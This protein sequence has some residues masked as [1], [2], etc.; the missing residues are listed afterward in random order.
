M[1]YNQLSIALLYEELKGQDRAEYERIKDKYRQQYNSQPRK[2]PFV[3]LWAIA[4]QKVRKN[5]DPSFKRPPLRETQKQQQARLL[6][7]QDKAT[8]AE[9]RERLHRR[10]Q[11]DN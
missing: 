3:K 6:I 11:V 9:L 10:T 1:F 4:L 7:S 5:H 2:T 8:I